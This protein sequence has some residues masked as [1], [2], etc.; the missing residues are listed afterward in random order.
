MYH[1]KLENILKQKII[2]LIDIK[3]NGMEYDMHIVDD[4]LI[5]Y[6]KQLADYYNDYVSHF[7]PDYNCNKNE[8]L[9]KILYDM[10]N[11]K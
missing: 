10:V 5:T 1:K 3:K 7:R 6:A 4:K 9:D 11:M 2:E 8:T